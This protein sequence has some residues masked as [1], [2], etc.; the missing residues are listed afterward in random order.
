LVYFNEGTNV[1]QVEIDG[2]A[3]VVNFSSTV[4][5]DTWYK[6]RLVVG[7][8]VVTVY[9]DGV[10]IGSGGNNVQRSAD[11]SFIGLHSYQ[12]EVWYRNI[13]AWNMSLPA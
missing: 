13:K 1:V 2:V 5:I 8:G 6:L 12:A 3:G 11:A 9:V 4:N 7:G 10:I